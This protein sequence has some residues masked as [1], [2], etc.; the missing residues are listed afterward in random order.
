MGKRGV[1]LVSVP[2]LGSLQ[3]AAGPRGG[4]GLSQTP[5]SSPH[6][7][8]D[9][10]QRLWGWD[11]VGP[12]PPSSWPPPEGGRRGNFPEDLGSPLR[13]QEPSSPKGPLQLLGKERRGG[14]REFPQD[15]AWW[16]ADGRAAEEQA[17]FF[18]GLRGSGAARP[19]PQ[20]STPSPR[21]A[22]LRA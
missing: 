1:S 12:A 21:P 7:R 15:L 14:R 13:K 18:S 22:P 17:E 5:H 9:P 19:P 20:L 11:I 3:R 2:S 6:S 4:K 8:L 16:E 10:G